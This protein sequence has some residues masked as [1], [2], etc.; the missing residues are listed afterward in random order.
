MQFKCIGVEPNSELIKHQIANELLKVHGSQIDYSLQELDCE[1]VISLVCEIDE[2][3][4]PNKIWDQSCITVH[5]SNALAE[6]IIFKYEEKLINKIINE[7]YCYFNGNEKKSIAKHAI[8]ITQ[9]EDEKFI[10]KLLSIRRKNEIVRKLMEYFSNSSTLIIDGFVKFRLKGYLKELENVVDKAVDNYLVEREYS[11]FI[12]L[13]KYFIES[14]QP[15]VDVVHVYPINGKYSLT[16]SKGKEI[17][18]RSISELF[19][20]VEKGEINHDD[21][22][23]SSLV[24]LAP[25]KIILHKVKNIRKKELLETIKC[26]FDKKIQVCTGCKC[27]NS[28]DFGDL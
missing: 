8:K 24:T 19:I 14:K 23:I 7:N 1:G 25:E 13:L 26:V 28:G 16:N 9:N 11:E 5:F 27:C 2:A 18:D 10:Y 15:M 12:N 20:E 3:F 21:L 6:Y 4:Y 17:S 22:L